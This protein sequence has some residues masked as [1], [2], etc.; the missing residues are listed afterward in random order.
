M[1]EASMIMIVLSFPYTPL[2][3][4]P[5]YGF[6]KFQARVSG[7]SFGFVFIVKKLKKNLKANQLYPNKRHC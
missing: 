7:L 3:S 4:N 5:S 1:D 6:R 2:R